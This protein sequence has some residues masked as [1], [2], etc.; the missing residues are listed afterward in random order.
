MKVV[1][2]HRL[3]S[4]LAKPEH[5]GKLLKWA[6]ELGD[7]DIEYLPRM[8]IKAQALAD[9]IAEFTVPKEEGEHDREAKSLWT[10]YVDGASGE[11]GVGVGA[12][13][14]SCSGT[15][16]LHAEKIGFPLTNNQAE[17][18]ALISGLYTLHEE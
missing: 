13:L 18:E 5:S 15:T 16:L 6:A 2:D 10:L 8:A 1:T 14:R 7:I 3:K 12:V 4:V 11:R 17:Y 9:F